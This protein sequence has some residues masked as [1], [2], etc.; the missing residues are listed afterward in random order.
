M[1]REL[2]TAMNWMEMTKKLTYV[3]YFALLRVVRTAQEYYSNEHCSRDDVLRDAIIEA[4]EAL[5]EHLRG[6]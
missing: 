2:D 4:L 1:T 3:E 5:P 6:E